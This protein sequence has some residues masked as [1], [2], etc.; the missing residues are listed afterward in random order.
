MFSKSKL[1]LYI[2]SF[3]N[4]TPFS[5]LYC[6]KSL[7]KLTSVFHQSSIPNP[8]QNTP[9][10]SWPITMI[11]SL[12]RGLSLALLKPVHSSQIS[13]IQSNSI[14]LFLPNEHNK[15]IGHSNISEPKQRAPSGPDLCSSFDLGT[16]AAI[17]GFPFSHAHVHCCPAAANGTWNTQESSCQSFHGNS[18]LPE[19]VP[20]SLWLGFPHTDEKVEELAD[21]KLHTVRSSRQGTQPRRVIINHYLINWN[22]LSCK[23]WMNCSIKLIKMDKKWMDIKYQSGWSIS[24]NVPLCRAAQ[25]NG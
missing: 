17:V 9:N 11:H 2:Q 7:N 15:L 12:N 18:M 25:L 5:M 1:H 10:L 23:N 14:G 3:S 21:F 24:N 20:S 19:E 22:F 6:V 16:T 4:S 13:R 8:S